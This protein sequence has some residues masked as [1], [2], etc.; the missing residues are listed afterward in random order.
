MNWINGVPQQHLPLTDRALQFGDGFFTTARL[1]DGEIR[2]LA[3][4]LERLAITAKHLLFDDLNII[5]L[6]REMLAAAATGNNGVIKTIISRGSG[7]RGYSFS[8]CGTPLRIVSLTTAPEHYPAWR[9]DGIRLGQSPVRLG[10]NPLLAGIKHLNRL[11][12]V[13][14]H[15]HLDHAGTDE[16]LVLDTDGYLVECCSAN[17][18]WRKGRQVFTPSLN[19]A[20]VAGVMRRRVLT[21]LPALGYPSQEVTTGP[22]VLKQ[23]DEIFITNALLPVVPVNIIG[24]YRYPD[25]TLFQLL[26]PHC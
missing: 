5:S 23:A 17:I 14:I 10:R 4:H 18:F 25:R 22:D 12:Q 11:E 20:G 15:A 2:F 26:A 6:R 13:L 8:T 3:W 7:E 21:L 16:M 19:H 9:R 24:Q 1:Q